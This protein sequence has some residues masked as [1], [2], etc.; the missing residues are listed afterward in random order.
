M[1]SLRLFS[2][3]VCKIPC[4]R[5]IGKRVPHSWMPVE[6]SIKCVFLEM[7]FWTG[8][9]VKNLSVNQGGTTECRWLRDSDLCDSGLQC[10]SSVEV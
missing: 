1:R 10:L 4:F 9:E 7:L 2:E 3:L 6:H 5:S 8:A